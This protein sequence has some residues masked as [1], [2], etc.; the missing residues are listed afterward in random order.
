[1]IT[2]SAIDHVVLRVIDAAAMETFYRNVL[3]CTVE[4]RREDVGLLQLRAGTSL[5][6]LVTIDG[7]GSCTVNGRARGH[8][9]VPSLPPRPVGEATAGRPAPASE[10]RR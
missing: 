4:D 7:L 3:G 9:R 6:D 10:S 1:M 2:L 5:I 8:G